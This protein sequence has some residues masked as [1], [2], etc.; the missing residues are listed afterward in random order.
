[1]IHWWHSKAPPRPER[2]APPSARLLPMEMRADQ[3][4]DE[5]TEYYL[6][7][8]DLENLETRTGDYAEIAAYRLRFERLAAA[9][10]SGQKAEPVE[11]PACASMPRLEPRRRE[12]SHKT[13]GGTTTRVLA[14]RRIGRRS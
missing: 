2:V 14:Q 8:T 3:A 6:R 13:D 4:A 10:L 12:G 7:A 5:W 9:E 11:L 1:M